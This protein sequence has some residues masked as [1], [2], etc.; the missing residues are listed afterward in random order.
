M[1]CA[2]FQQAMPTYAFDAPEELDNMRKEA[3][4]NGQLSF[5]TAC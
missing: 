2:L 5:T 3:E 4:Q 1:L